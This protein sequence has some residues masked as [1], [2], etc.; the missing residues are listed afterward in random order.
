LK[1]LVPLREPEGRRATGGTARARGPALRLADDAPRPFSKG[2]SGDCIVQA[3]AKRGIAYQ[4]LRPEQITNT[5]VAGST[6]AEFCINGAAYYFGGGCLGVADPHG[7]RVPGM[8][9]DG[10]KARFVGKKDATKSFLREHGVSVPEGA[11]FFRDAQHEAASF[12]ATFAPFL[13]DGVCVKPANGMWG[14]QVHVGIRDMPSFRAAFAAVGQHYKRVLVE[15]TVPG[16]VYRFTCLAGR[17]IAVEFGRPANV[18]GDGSHTI[19]ELV[20]L[21]NIKRRLN[22]AHAST[23]LRFGQRERMF[24]SQAGLE[25][26]HVPETGKLVF[27]SSLSNLHQGAE[28]IDVTDVVHHSY[29]E[30]IEHAVD[31]V[32]SLVLCG[33]DV[34]IQDASLQATGD[35]YHV[36]ELN[37]GPGFQTNHYP[38]RGQSR[39]VAG[40]IMDYLTHRTA[41]PDKPEID[42]DP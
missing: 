39:D 42:S 2:S 14:R 32:P 33:V 37:C 13:P 11:V 36:L 29:I 31:L 5:E 1:F 16:T 12:F 35:N 15:E 20:T 8:V 38:W 19:A 26:D 7:V 6:I 23:L 27:L 22:P 4:Y 18:E 21:K 41:L 40:A 3:L 34:V 9:I 28:F 24:L 30:L 25:P 10:P 17:V